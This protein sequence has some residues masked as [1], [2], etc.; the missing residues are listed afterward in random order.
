M[1]STQGKLAKN[2]MLMYIRMIIM[3][4]ISVYSSRLLLKSLGVEDF[5]IYNLVGSVI[6]VFQSFRMMFASST[7]RFLNVEMGKNNHQALQM[8]FSMSLIVNVGVAILFAVLS[9]LIGIWFIENKINISPDKI[10]DAYY[11][12]HFS[13]AAAVIGI[14]ATS[15]DAVI[16]ANERMNFYAY[17]SILEV[18]LKLLIILP[19]WF[20]PDG[21]LIWYSILIFIVSFIIRFIK[22]AYCSSNFPESKFKYHWDKD[23]LKTMIT[24]AGWQLF[25][26]T[27]CAFSNNI[28][29]MM[30]NV[31]GG[32]VVNAARG[33]SYQVNSLMQQFII[34][35]SIVINPYCMRSYGE[36]NLS[37]MFRMLFFS[38]KIY[39]IIEA[40][41]II[42][43]FLLTKQILYLWLGIVPEYTVIYVQLILLWSIVKAFHPA[44]DT[45]FKAVGNL[46]IYQLTE[47]VILMLPLVFSYFT[48]K[49]NGNLIMPFVYIVLFEL[50]DLVAISYEAKYIASLDLKAFYD[51]VLFPSFLFTLLFG[52]ITV[53]AYFVINNITVLIGFAIIIDLLFLTASYCFLLS[54]EE[55]L[56]LLNIIQS[57]LKKS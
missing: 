27:A 46:K 32:P 56:S 28:L 15:Y 11:V 17:S 13:V 54:K 18:V 25:G 37:S 48:L 12:L 16:I 49:Y 3:I 55:K 53:Y 24:F 45:M 7:Q 14:V 21:R 5:G 4:I 34:N 57:K 6:A 52:I 19:L 33:I 23:Y 22:S 9:E 10:V 44:I 39:Y 30:L 36:D 47:G 50:L 43:L 31:F 26:N 42:P 40:C 51:K 20:L 2:T 38:S 35:I 8:V 29:N 41:I 1:A